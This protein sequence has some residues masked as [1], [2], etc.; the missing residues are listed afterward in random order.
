MAMRFWLRKF[1]IRK[2]GLFFIGL[3]GVVFKKVKR[4]SR[5]YAVNCAKNLKLL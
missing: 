4:P 3:P 1:K 2:P 5:P